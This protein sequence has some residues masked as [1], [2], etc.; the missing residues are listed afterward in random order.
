MPFA[1]LLDR[2]D[3]EAKQAE[4]VVSVVSDTSCEFF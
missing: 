2:H 3:D 1:H 4:C